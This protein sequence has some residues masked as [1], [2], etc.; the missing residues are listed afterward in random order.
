MA[1]PV[2]RCGC[3]AA[4]ARVWGRGSAPL[5]PLRAQHHRRLVLAPPLAARQGRRGS[6]GRRGARVIRVARRGGEGGEGAGGDATDGHGRREQQLLRHRARRPRRRPRRARRVAVLLARAAHELPVLGDAGA[7]ALG[8]EAG[9]D[10]IP[11]RRPQLAH[12]LDQRRLLLRRPPWLLAVRS[13][14]SLRGLGCGGSVVVN[15]RSVVKRGVGPCAHR[16]V[17]HRPRIR[18]RSSGSRGEDVAAR[19]RECATLDGRSA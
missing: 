12:Q 5:E 18:R 6:G 15:R 11:R 7:G 3:A 4:R 10:G 19:S 16:I 9:G 14:R 13:A 2:R 8:L 17:L 1:R